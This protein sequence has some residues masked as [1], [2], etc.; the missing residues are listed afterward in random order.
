[1]MRFNWL[2]RG[3]TQD[4]A[5]V[6]E[7]IKELDSYGYYSVLLTYHSKADDYF[8][9]AARVLTN[10][11]KIKLMLAIRTYAISPEYLSMICKSL[12]HISNE[13]ITLNVC[14]GDFDNGEPDVLDNL[15]DPGPFLTAPKRAE[16]TDKWMEKFLNL[17]DFNVPEIYMAGHSE[18]TKNMALHYNATHISMFDMYLNDLKKDD[19]V[20]NKKQLITIVAVVRETQ[21]EAD[22]FFNEHVKK[23]AHQIYTF[24]GTKEYLKAKIK[25]I[26]S[27][28]GTE[29]LLSRHMNDNQVQLVHETI[30]ELSCE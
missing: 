12:N 5:T 2:H 11:Q 28:G 27:M 14:S 25:D 13:K 30:K 26:E 15:V 10:K 9:K 24:C 18:H 7:L 16:Y 19:R 4:V 6:E 3:Y 20:T 17:K 23:G 8:I 21:E 1:M 29:I 22:L